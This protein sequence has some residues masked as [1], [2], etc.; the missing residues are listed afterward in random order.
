[1]TETHKVVHTDVVSI[2]P[3]V[4]GVRFVYDD[5]EQEVA[6]VGPQDAAEFLAAVQLGEDLVVGVN[7]LL[8][9]AAKADE[10]RRKARKPD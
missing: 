3:G 5:G 7:P 1:M 8:L 2:G 4:Y 9:N 6:E 10:L